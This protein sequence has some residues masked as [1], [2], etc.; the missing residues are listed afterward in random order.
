MS[1]KVATLLVVSVLFV[2]LVATTAFAGGRPEAAAPDQYV[3]SVAVHPLEYYREGPMAMMEYV[4]R[5]SGGRITFETFQFPELGSDAEITEM[6]SIG[7]IHM[8]T[9]LADAGVGTMMPSA[10]AL[11]LPFLF[12]SVDVFVELMDG[13][14]FDEMAQVMYEESGGTIR[15]LAA[16]KSSRR[17]LYSTKGPVR[18]PQDLADHA[19]TMRVMPSPLHVSLWEGLG[20]SAVSLPAA[21]RYTALQTGM[22]DA[23]EGGLMSAWQA[24]LMEVQE[25]VTLTNHAFGTGFIFINE[26]FFQS[27]PQDLQQILIDGA[28]V[29]AA[30]DN[31]NIPKHSEEAMRLM[32][33]AGIQIIELTPDEHREWQEIAQPIGLQFLTT[34][35]GLD[36]AWV[37][38][39]I[40]ATA[41]A[42][43]RI[44]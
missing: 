36:P 32:I 2:L 22:I 33:E 27:L 15:I 38:R 1:R 30:Y 3:I 9:A 7:E 17:H 44:R 39:V 40:D 14:F 10:Q 42:E 21:E 29:A 6:V 37:E 20:T 26:E 28:W 8:G 25:Y 4:E 31:E 34:D 19:I 11:T 43:A 35:A 23:T 41:D 18:R 12:P 16:M 24:G 13:P 5:E